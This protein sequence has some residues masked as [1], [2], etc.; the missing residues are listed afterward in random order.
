MLVLSLQFDQRGV[1]SLSDAAVTTC[2]DNAGCAPARDITATIR[3]SNPLVLRLRL[4]VRMR[5]ADARPPSG[6]DRLHE[7]RLPRSG[8]A[9]QDVQTWLEFDLDRIDD[10]EVINTKKTKHLWT[11]TPMLPYV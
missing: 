8:F 10:G 9:G 5:S 4:T 3:S 1:C 2:V 11:G 6:G 7:H